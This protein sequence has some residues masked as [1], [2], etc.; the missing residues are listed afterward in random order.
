[1]NII[2]RIT[3]PWNLVIILLGI[4]LLILL[5][6]NASRLS[7]QRD[8]ISEAVNRDN[9]R[10]FA[11]PDSR[12]LHSVSDRDAAV[13]PDTIRSYE[14]RFNDACSLHNMY[15]QLIPIFPMLGILG[16]VYGLLGNLGDVDSMMAGLTTA[17]DTTFY[18]LSV[19]IVLKAVDAVYPSR[20]INATDV[21]LDDFKSRIGLSELFERESRSGAEEGFGN[22]SKGSSGKEYRSGN[23]GSS[24]KEYRSGNKGSS[25][26]AFGNEGRDS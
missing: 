2:S 26:E 8:N 17:L 3:D 6:Q 18:G 5:L 21:M 10:Y 9:R 4:A 1:M 20:V 7:S 19:A 23:K 22:D 15:A 14:T 13:T 11:D 12:E 25:G 16:T 24:G